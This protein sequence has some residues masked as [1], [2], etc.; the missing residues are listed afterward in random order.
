MEKPDDLDALAARLAPDV[1]RTDFDAPGYALLDLGA[2]MTPRD[3]RA[4]LVGLG[5]ALAREYGRRHGS[6]LR[7]HSVSRFDQQAKTRPHRDGGP[8]ASLLILGYEPTE[9]LS[10]VSLMDYSRAAFDRGL[11]PQE[12]LDRHNPAFGDNVRLLLGYGVSLT[13]FRPAH[14]QVLIVNNSQVPYE[15]RR[16]GMLGLLHHAEI[17]TPRPDRSRWIDSLLLGM[18]DAGL[19]QRQLAAFVEGATAAS[20]AGE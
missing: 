9:V 19:T 17:E 6:P 8:D 15:E 5:E 16:R 7:F 2:E 14:H 1:F 12:Y 3:F 18:I 13:T 4:A 20:R 11:T 10:R